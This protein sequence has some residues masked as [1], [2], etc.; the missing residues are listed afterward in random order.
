[1]RRSLAPLAAAAALAGCATAG[2]AKPPAAANPPGGPA[3]PG[4]GGVQQGTLAGGAE[5][6]E[7]GRL[8]TTDQSVPGPFVL[9]YLSPGGEVE[10]VSASGGAA[11]GR[12]LGPL[13]QPLHVAR[14]MVVRL[15]T[16]SD[17]VYA[18]YRPLPITRPLDAWNGRA[19]LVGV[20]GGQPEPWTLREIAADHVTIERSRTFRVIP[21]RR[22]AEI[23]WTDLTGI[24]PTP[25]I[26][27]TPE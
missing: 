17:V 11:V 7:T 5:G 22:I 13:G 15:P 1:M 14:G 10:V 2:P 24:D 3:A 20:A 21:V 6:F 26:V 8:T 25:R 16:P 4:Q 12:V 27:L 9:T 18:G 23:T 19:V